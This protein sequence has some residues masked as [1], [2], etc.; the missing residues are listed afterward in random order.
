MSELQ[1][2]KVVAAYDGAPVLHGVT[3]T[4]P[5]GELA[6]VLGPSGSGKSTL[7]RVIAGL[8]LP[9]E[10]AIVVGG[11]VLTGPRLAVPPERRRIGLVPQDAALFPHLD[12][13]ANVAF[14]LAR[15]D[16]AGARPEQL[17][18][19]VGLAELAHRMPGEL[20]GGQ[21]HRVALA[22]A[23]A[24]EPDVILLDEPFS[25]LDASLRAEVRAQVRQVLRATR[26]TAVLVT[27]DQDEAL[28]MADLVAVLDR[29]RL[30]QAGSPAQ[31]YDAP[32][33]R[34]LA[35]FVGG[36]VVVPGRWTGNAV[37]CALGEVPAQL[38]AGEVVRPGD[39]VELALRPEHLVLE[40]ADSPGVGTVA[41]VRHVAFFGHD[42][43]VTLDLPGVADPIEAR[44]L[45]SSATTPD[46]EV[47][48]RADRPGI[49][50][51][52]SAGS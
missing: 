8:H 41:L 31:I 50:F 45:G 23:L 25:A 3:F 7:L 46:T 30:V 29:G 48:V 36:A 51:A 21:R 22:R 11:R 40:P 34:W 5:S 1:V 14:G 38:G 20:S 52:A 44:V 33:S 27:H 13:R 47:R 37:A 32:R 16:R 6:A 2:R 10:G 35:Q 43:V 19:M 26:T 49:A 18:A 9:L 4:V 24:P 17:L 39:A 42:A 12:V 28:S 15:A